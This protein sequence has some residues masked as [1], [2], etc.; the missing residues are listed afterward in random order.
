VPWTKAGDLKEILEKVDIAYL[1]LESLGGRRKP[2]PDSPNGGW[3]VAQFRGYADHMSSGEFT[4]TAE[5]GDR[6]IR[7]LSSRSSEGRRSTIRSHDPGEWIWIPIARV[8]VTSNNRHMTQIAI[9]C[10]PHAP[11]DTEDVQR[12]LNDELDR[13]RDRAPHSAIRL[14]RLSQ[15]GPESEIDVGWQ[16]ELN[17]NGE[18]PVEDRTLREV[19]RDLRLLGLQPALLRGVGSGESSE[20]APTAPALA[21]NRE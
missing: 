18:A 19:L 11:I 14:L 20:E 4:S 15:P 2:N 21:T 6:S 17:G 5:A 10:H 13:L 3:R 16:I 9:R 7:S 8:A 1:H 12:W